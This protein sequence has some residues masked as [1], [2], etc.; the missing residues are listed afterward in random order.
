MN[1]PTKFLDDIIEET[2]RK[3][4]DYKRTSSLTEKE[5]IKEVYNLYQKQK[6]VILLNNMFDVKS[7]LKNSNNPWTYHFSLNLNWVIFFNHL[8]EKMSLLGY[9][10]IDDKE[11]LESIY[12][13]TNKLEIVLNHVDGI[14][15]NDDKI[16]LIKEDFSFINSDI[17][18]WKV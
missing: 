9:V 1:L 13:K 17:Q 7:V 10:D 11:D 5:L 6:D 18:K 4:K 15:E 12:N 3:F 2:E 16:Y 14:I 8:Y